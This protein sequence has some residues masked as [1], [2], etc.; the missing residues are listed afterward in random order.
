MKKLRGWRT[1]IC[2]KRNYTPTREIQNQCQP[3][4]TNQLLRH[5]S[6]GL[7]FIEMSMKIL[8][9]ILMSNL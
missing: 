2:K 1:N 8:M 3:H 4:I 9:K 5:D 6:R 7:D